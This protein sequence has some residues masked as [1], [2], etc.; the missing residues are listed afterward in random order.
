MARNQILLLA[1]ILGA[2]TVALGAFGA[3]ALR[4]LVD[5]KTV[6]SYN[7]G[8]QYQ[9]YHTLLLLFIGLYQM[10]HSSKWITIAARLLI[11]GIILFSGSLYAMT[12]CKAA[13]M[14]NMNW[15]GA[16]TPLGGLC[17][18]A[19]WLCLIP[20]IKTGKAN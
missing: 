13:G 16:I 3:H 11:A 15:L 6:Q 5:E 20:S 8:V 9:F 7:T 14:E 19:G 4:N 2:L 10:Q 18:I 1:F 17:F 12:F